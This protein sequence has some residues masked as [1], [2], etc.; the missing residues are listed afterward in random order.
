MA[1]NKARLNLLVTVL[2]VAV[3]GWIVYRTA[4]A[5]NHVTTRVR[6]DTRPADDA[7]L[8][9]WLRAQ[10]GV[11]AATVTRDGDEVVVEYSLPVFRSGPVPDVAGQ[12]GRLGYTGFR[13]E[14]TTITGG[15][16]LF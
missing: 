9:D 12:M 16:R 4:T 6:Y 15:V 5:T 14:A 13:R 11:S 1:A 3:V 7:A 10:P 2:G 8:A